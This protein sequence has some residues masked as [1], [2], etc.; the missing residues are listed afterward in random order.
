MKNHVTRSFIDFFNNL[1]VS[2]IIAGTVV[3]LVGMTSSAVIVFQAASALGLTPLEAS[4]WLGSLC[5]GM[6]FLTIFL[7]LYY[8][9]PVLMAWSTPGAAILATGLIGVSYPQA[10]GAFIF[11][12]SLIFLCGVTKIFEKLMNKIP[13]GLSSAL[14]AG[15]L[16]HFALD[17]FTA[18]KTQ[19]YLIGVMFLSYL[20]SK[21]LFPKATMMLVLVMGFIVSYSSQL[22]HFNQIHFSWTHFQF[23]RPE[24]SLPVLLSIGI[25]LF[26]VTMA[27]QNLTGIV[28]MR[29]H[30]F[31]VPIS[32]LISWSGLMNLITAPFGGFAINLAAITAAIAMGKDA[33]AL[34]ERRYPAA[35]FSGILYLMIGFFAATVT[36]LFSAFPKEMIAGIAG[37]ALFGTISSCLHKALSHDQDR[38][39][40]FV[41]FALTA[42]GLSFFGI[43]SA[44]WGLI[45]GLLTQFLLVTNKEKLHAVRK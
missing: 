31:H 37:M 43:G 11:S 26:I 12:A 45:A 5:I 38:E 35:V 1:S 22:L 6:G 44:F 24:F 32:P 18:F 8:K 27:S 20:F 40:S 16:L 7:S 33:H 19:P 2:A 13:L 29:T 10:V 23:I 9:S 25:P 41:T 14:L 34:S 4:S 17:S 42:S 28:V 36:S 3:T 30:D 15:V 39:A 21:R